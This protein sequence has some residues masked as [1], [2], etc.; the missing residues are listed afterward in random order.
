LPDLRGQAAGGYG[1]AA[2]GHARAEIGGEDLNGLHRVV[3]IGKRFSHAHH[4]DVVDQ[5]AF[6]RFVFQR[7]KLS[8]NFSR[9]QVALESLAR[10]QAEGA[11]HGAA[12]L[13]GNAKRPVAFP[14]NENAFDV[15]AVFQREKRLLRAVL[16]FL[17]L[18]DLRPDDPGGAGKLFPEI[19]GEGC[20]GV[21]GGNAGL[22]QPLHDLARPEFFLALRGDEYMIG[23]PG[24]TPEILAD[25]LL[26]MKK[27]DADMLGIGPFI[28]HPD[29]PLTGLDNDA[30][31][32]T[33]RVIAIA[34]LL[35]RNTNI[36]ATTALSTLH[37]WGRI[38]ALQA[39][40]N[41]VMPD[42]TPELFKSRYDIY[43]GRADVGSAA[44]IMAK[45]EKDFAAIGRTILYSPGFR[46]KKLDS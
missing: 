10:G 42:F 16:R 40:A 24:Q 8:D 46:Q 39:G 23:L 9:C 29:T 13:R 19:A 6:G 27:L 2:A 12:R 30:F 26:I 33:C 37:P 5:G 38:Q 36:P 35:T 31:D 32:L 3:V 43:P 18:D 21:K 28:A 11:V 22:M 1:D 41:V 25:D 15:K 44:E 14:R 7:H 34:R 17:N 4:D 45:L 20:H